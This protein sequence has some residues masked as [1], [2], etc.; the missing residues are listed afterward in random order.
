MLR[1][2]A[3]ALI[4]SLMLA[5]V[6]SVRAGEL[7]IHVMSGAEEKSQEYLNFFGT[8]VTTLSDELEESR[9][10]GEWNPP[11]DNWLILL[12]QALSMTGETL[13]EIHATRSEDLRRLPVLIATLSERSDAATVRTAARSAKRLIVETATQQRETPPPPPAPEQKLKTNNPR[14]KQRAGVFISMLS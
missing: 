14:T 5:V 1:T 8:F 11:S 10:S 13:I 12:S 3:V 4:A 9:K 7:R 6:P 2:I